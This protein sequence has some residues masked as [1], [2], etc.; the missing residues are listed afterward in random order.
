MYVIINYVVKFLKTCL[1]VP[2]Y[3]SPACKATVAQSHSNIESRSKNL[4]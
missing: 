4:Y 2:V 3:S 1:S